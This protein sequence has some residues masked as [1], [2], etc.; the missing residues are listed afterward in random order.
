MQPI[1]ERFTKPDS[2]TAE[3]P[4]GR[5][6]QKIIYRPSVHRLLSKQ[7]DRLQE[8][9]PSS[10]GTQM[11]AWSHCDNGAPRVRPWQSTLVGRHKQLIAVFSCMLAGYC[12]LAYR[13]N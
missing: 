2:D 10:A 8:L 4:L 1:I 7:H 3:V 12:L 9:F 13:F 5:A 11:T 6:R